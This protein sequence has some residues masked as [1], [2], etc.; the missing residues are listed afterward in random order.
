M[1][2]LLSILIF[3][4]STG[5]LS[6]QE[7]H[8][9]KVN[10]IEKLWMV[11]PDR[12]NFIGSRGIQKF[13]YGRP[14]KSEN[15][16]EHYVVRWRHSGKEVARHLVLL[17]EYRLALNPKESFVEKRSY[18][19]LRRGTYKWVF[20]NI[21]IRFTTGGKVDRWKVSLVLDGRVV[22]EKRSATWHAMEGT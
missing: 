8:V 7:F 4:V 12:R 20:K 6:A 16:G 9:T 2:R 5:S 15:A 17:F 22:A 1:K 14:I 10:R 18:K 19:D 3:L 13:D 21:G 11:P